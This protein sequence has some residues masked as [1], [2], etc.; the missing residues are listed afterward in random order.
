MPKVDRPEERVSFAHPLKNRNCSGPEHHRK[1]GTPPRGQA[2]AE[3]DGYKNRDQHQLPVA[4]ENKV[5]AV[6]GLVN[7]EFSRFGGG[8][9]VRLAS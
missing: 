7:Y 9:H 8:F 5:R 1:T 3:A 2:E 6:S 4:A